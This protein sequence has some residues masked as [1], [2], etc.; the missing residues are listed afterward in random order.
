MNKNQDL[1]N[2]RIGFENG[3]ILVLSVFYF[4][5]QLDLGLCLGNWRKKKKLGCRI[6]C[7]IDTLKIPAVL[8]Q[9]QEI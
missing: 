2:T 3:N 6:N 4:L 7:T 1:K 9:H 8:R 5:P